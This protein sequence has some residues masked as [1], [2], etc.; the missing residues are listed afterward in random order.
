MK[1]KILT[2]SFLCFSLYSFGQTV[3][4]YDVS[5]NVLYDMGRELKAKADKIDG[6]KYTSDAFEPANINFLEN[7]TVLVRYNA[8]DDEIEF[9]RNGKNFNLIKTSQIE[10]KFI[11][12]NKTYVYTE[13]FSKNLNK[14]FGYLV[15]LNKK[16]N[17]SIYLRESVSLIPGK[18]A[19]T[20]YEVSRAAFFQP[21]KEEFLIEIDGKITTIPK[22]KKEFLILFGD[23][24]TAVETFIKTN[25]L[26]YSS[27]EDLIKLSDFLNQN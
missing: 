5:S 11:K 26:N 13:Y 4:N 9:S 12:S 16:D 25:K 6:S 3:S 24:S 8:Y 10:V 18:E 21:N 22:K 19:V 15:Q 27:K 1:N 2:L 23:K 20:G 17:Y 14:V 7:Q